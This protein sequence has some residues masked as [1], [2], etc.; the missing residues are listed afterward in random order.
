MQSDARVEKIFH[1]IHKNAVY[2]FAVRPYVDRAV[3]SIY[4][5]H[6]M[7]ETSM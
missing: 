7:S 1:K 3:Y 2:I 4:I 6:E 5:V